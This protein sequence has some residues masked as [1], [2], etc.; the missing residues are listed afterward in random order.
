[1]SMLLYSKT[2][3]LFVQRGKMALAYKEVAYRDHV[4]AARVNVGLVDQAEE[5]STP[6]PLSPPASEF[7]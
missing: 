3:R 5:C 7:E 6:D 2:G 1:M 4:L